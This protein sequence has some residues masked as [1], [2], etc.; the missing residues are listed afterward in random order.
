MKNLTIKKVNE[1]AVNN[2]KEIIENYISENGSAKGL[3]RDKAYRQTFTTQK[4]LTT[5]IRNEREKQF[6]DKLIGGEIKDEEIITTDGLFFD[7]LQT[8]DNPGGGDL[9][10][11]RYDNTGKD[12]N[13]VVAVIKDFNGN[14][15]VLKSES[16]IDIAISELF[17]DAARLQESERH[18]YRNNKGK[19]VRGTYSYP[20]IS[21]GEAIKNKTKYITVNADFTQSR[22]NRLIDYDLPIK[23]GASGQEVELLQK[24]MRLDFPNKKVVVDSYFST[25]TQSI[26]KY[27]TGKK[28]ITLN[29]YRDIIQSKRP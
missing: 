15:S 16:D 20:V 24:W 13:R 5:K 14:I 21:L 11:N 25:N 4:R 26:L 22:N 17:R 8:R 28:E 29:E 6:S 18:Y 9:F 2:R 19:L 7:V 12:F 3:K 27:A 10:Y 23:I 1:N